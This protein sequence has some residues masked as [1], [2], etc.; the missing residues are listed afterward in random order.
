MARASRQASDARR[1]AGASPPTRP[2]GKEGASA[3]ANGVAAGMD[4]SGGRGAR[5]CIEVHAD[6][7]RIPTH[8]RR[9]CMP[10]MEATRL[11]RSTQRTRR[12]LSA[13]QNHSTSWAF[14]TGTPASARSERTASYTPPH[15]AR[16][17][18]A[19]APVALTGHYC[20]DLTPLTSPSY[21]AVRPYGRG[22]AR[23]QSQ[24][25]GTRYHPPVLERLPQ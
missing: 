15:C 20:T 19:D 17:S 21:S 7:N 4:A 5:A 11:P 13:A 2:A 23:C 18:R 25:L 10:P 3:A 8:A 16:A 9:M 6:K 1:S 22:V 24:R 12:M 14:P